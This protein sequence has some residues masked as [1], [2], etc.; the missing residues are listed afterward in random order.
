[1]EN[2][3]LWNEFNN[4]LENNYFEE[5]LKENLIKYGI[6]NRILYESKNFII[7]PTVGPLVNG[8]IL[9]CPKEHF[10]SFSQ[11]DRE[12]LDEVEK[13]KSEVRKIYR[14]VY[15]KETVFFEHGML[16]CEDKGGACT[17]HA[18]IHCLPTTIDIIDDFLEYSF[19]VR[20]ISKFQEIMNQLKRNS[21]Y[22]YYENQKQVKIIMDSPI[23]E[24]QF[25]RK[26]LAIKLGKLDKLHWKYS[27]YSSD[28]FE[29]IKVLPTAFKAINLKGD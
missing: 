25:I 17:S 11:L 1:M 4:K 3:S 24:S 6:K 10:L 27:L 23:I 21:A 5:Y 16:S 20:N 28:I 18:H 22:L 12:L 8:H 7:I 2:W 9:I 14:K 29:M 26:L 13:I 15:G 19:N